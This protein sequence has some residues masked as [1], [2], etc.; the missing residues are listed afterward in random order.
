MNQITDL[1]QI[2]WDDVNRYISEMTKMP[3]NE[4]WVKV[5]TGEITLSE[6]IRRLESS[7]AKIPH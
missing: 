4:I 7:P 3:D 5:R 2:N 1:L 6:A